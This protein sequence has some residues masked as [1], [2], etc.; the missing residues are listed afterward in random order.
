M[1]SVRMP[2][3]TPRIISLISRSTSD[4]TRWQPLPRDASVNV[5]CDGMD[6]GVVEKY[7]VAAGGGDDSFVEAG[8]VLVTIQS[9]PRSSTARTRYMGSATRFA[10]PKRNTCRGPYCDRRSRRARSRRSACTCGDCAYNVAA[11]YSGVSSC[12][13]A[14]G[15]GSRSGRDGG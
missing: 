8:D 1:N 5:F 15:R 12:V 10:R 6:G 9:R 2:T 14:P 3:C 13:G 4:C 11:S 7:A